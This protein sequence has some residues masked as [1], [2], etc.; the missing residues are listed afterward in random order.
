MSSADSRALIEQTV[1]RF[2][3]DVP[4]LKPLQ[5]VMKVQLE[6]RGDVPVW[7]VEVPGPTVAKD[8]AADARIEVAMPR[9]FFNEIA[10][11]GQLEDWV[12]AYEHGYVKV[13]G[14]RAVLSLIGK[15][16]VRQRVRGHS[17]R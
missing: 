9:T 14:D 7:R 5:L 6:A 11:D 13:S 1:R 15:V 10:K 16:I 12:E 4:A 17:G 2:G 8:P 3:E